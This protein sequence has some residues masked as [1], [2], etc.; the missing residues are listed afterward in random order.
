M[1]LHLSGHPCYHSGRTQYP[2]SSVCGAAPLAKS[3]HVLL[4]LVV[5]DLGVDQ[6]RWLQTDRQV[7]APPGSVRPPALTGSSGQLWVPDVS[8]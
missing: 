8:K 6:A 2:V 1:V 7:G 3:R 5:P 4:H